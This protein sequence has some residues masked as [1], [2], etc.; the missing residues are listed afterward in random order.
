MKKNDLT[1]L[2]NKIG[3]TFRNKELLKNGIS[4]ELARCVLP[5][6]TYTQFDQFSI[7]RC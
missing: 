7:I 3:Y 6:C 4:R 2:E 5:L 1:L